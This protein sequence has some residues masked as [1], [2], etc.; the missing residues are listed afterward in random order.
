M[1][2]GGEIAEGPGAAR[3]GEDRRRDAILA[4]TRELERE[5]AKAR[6]GR[7]AEAPARDFRRPRRII[8]VKE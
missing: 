8:E 1:R 3:P 2:C 5:L 7:S 4:K 6:E